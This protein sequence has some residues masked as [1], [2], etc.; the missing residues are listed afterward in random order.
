MTCNAVRPYP[1][2]PHRQPAAARGVGASFTSRK[3]RGEAVDAQLADGRPCRAGDVVRRQRDAGIDI[4]NNGEQQREAFFL[5]VRRRMSGFGG[6]WTGRRAPMSTRYPGFQGS[7]AAR[8]SAR[9]RSDQHARGVPTAIGEVRYLDRAAIEREC[10]DFRAALDKPR[11]PFVEPFMTAPSP[12]I[13]AAALRNDY[14]PSEDDYLAALG[15]ALHVEYE[16]IVNARLPVAARLPGPGDG[17]A[18]LLPGPTAWRFPRL[19]RSRRCNHQCRAASTSR[20]TGSACT[21]AGAITKARM[22]ATW[23]CRRSCRHPAQAEGRRLRAA[24]RQ[25]APCA[26]IRGAARLSARC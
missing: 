14:Y 6:A 25:S 23:S 26:R 16:T 12:G 11:Q 17:T 9:S 13:V 20:V 19:R 10:A 8:R 1:D 24:V 7:L 22:I 2:H 3:A 5:Y 4:G 21:P 15:E 18:H